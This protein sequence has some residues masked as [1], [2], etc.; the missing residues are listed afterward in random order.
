MNK[1]FLLLS[2]FLYV[3]AAVRPVEKKYGKYM[4]DL[5]EHLSK[6]QAKNG[7]KN[8]KPFNLKENIEYKRQN[9][10]ELY[11]ND[12]GELKQERYS[13]QEVRQILKQNSPDIRYLVN[14]LE[15]IFGVYKYEPRDKEKVLRETL[16]S[17]SLCFTILGLLSNEIN[18]INI[19]D[20]TI[21]GFVIKGSR[22][23]ANEAKN[24]FNIY[25][26]LS[27]TTV[28]LGTFTLPIFEH[29]PY[30]LP[31]LINFYD[32]IQNYTYHKKNGNDKTISYLCPLPQFLIDVIRT[33]KFGL[34]FN[35][36][37]QD[38]NVNELFP[39][40][41]SYVLQKPDNLPV[42]TNDE[43]QNERM[44]L[45]D[46]INKYAKDIPYRPVKNNG[47]VGVG[48]IIPKER[49]LASSSF[50]NA[51]EKVKNF[52]AKA[53]K[54][55]MDNYS[56]ALYFIFLSQN[57]RF[58]INDNKSKSRLIEKIKIQNV[59]ITNT[60]Y[61]Q[62]YTIQLLLTTGTWISANANV[63]KKNIFIPTEI[64]KRATANIEQDILLSYGL[65]VGPNGNG[66]GYKF[67]NVEFPLKDV[68]PY[69]INALAS[70]VVN[71]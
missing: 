19:T 42:K 71:K 51:R 56:S 11:R 15:V 25:V 69:N 70:A 9:N 4:N 5:D 45:L 54:I 52:I 41:L 12:N 10:Y 53:G 64:I 60:G 26:I 17:E 27:N 30:T 18:K 28:P 43:K 29:A 20:S 65:E 39:A 40:T 35:F 47:A 3:V 14:D 57:L 31:Y 33:T 44:K 62:S 16:K 61:L 46:T 58:Q 1:F 49:L 24:S 34:K 59:H 8:S 7:Y 68:L 50:F 21:Y 6:Q 63:V 13:V 55:A 2:L 38:I 67:G 66:L 37:G 22:L 23:R 36:N 32:R 48:V